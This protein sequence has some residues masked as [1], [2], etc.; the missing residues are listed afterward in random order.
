MREVACPGRCFAAAALAVARS[1]HSGWRPSCLFATSAMSWLVKKVVAKHV[2]RHFHAP[3]NWPGRPGTTRLWLMGGLWIQ[4]LGVDCRRRGT[5][6]CRR[7]G[8]AAGQLP[9]SART[10]RRSHGSALTNVMP[11][12]TSTAP[13]TK[14]RLKGSLSNSTPN[15]T[16]NS[17]VMNE[18]T[19]RLEAR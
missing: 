3:A 6:A 11:N 10:L 4:V 12:N 14:L 13:T 18:N 16:P 15:V 5:A 7:T 19:A 1:R 9:S 8:L 2:R 17:G